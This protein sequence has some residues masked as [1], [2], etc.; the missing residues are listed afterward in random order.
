MPMYKLIEYSNNYLKPS[1]SLWKYYRDESTL[2]A[3][4]TIINF[5]GNSS[6]F[7]FKQKITEKTPNDRK[8]KDVSIAVI[9]LKNSWN[10]TY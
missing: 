1:W 8:T 4:I 5:S 3:D 2:N 10:A 6:S 7:R 9:A